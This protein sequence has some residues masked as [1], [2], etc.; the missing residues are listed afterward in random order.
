[1]QRRA[2]V[3]ITVDGRGAVT[4]VAAIF[5][6]RVIDSAWTLEECEL[7][8]DVGHVKGIGSFLSRV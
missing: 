3:P 7:D 8:S 1:M 4:A 5:D 2:A 6:G